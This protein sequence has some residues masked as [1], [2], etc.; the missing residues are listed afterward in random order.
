MF[1]KLLAKWLLGRTT[2]YSGGV[3]SIIEREVHLYNLVENRAAK[4]IEV[5]EYIFKEFKAECCRLKLEGKE[6]L[7]GIP[8]ILGSRSEIVVS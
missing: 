1:K 5:P 8:V 6:T 4:K 3:F 7:F 2:I